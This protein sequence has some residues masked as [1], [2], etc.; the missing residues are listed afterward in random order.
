M[1]QSNNTTGLHGEQNEANAIGASSAS[2]ALNV[3]A[4]FLANMPP[5]V[6]DMIDAAIRLAEAHGPQELGAFLSDEANMVIW[7]PCVLL[8][9]AVLTWRWVLRHI[10]DTIAAVF[11]YKTRPKRESTLVNLFADESSTVQ[12]EGSEVLGVHIADNDAPHYV[13]N[14]HNFL[15]LRFAYND[16]LGG[17]VLWIQTHKI[18]MDDETV[19]AGLKAIRDILVECAEKDV[20]FCSFYDLRTYQLPGVSGGYARANQLIAWC[21]TLATPQKNLINDHIHSVA[22]IL[23]SGFAARILKKIVDFFLWATKPPMDPKIFMDDADAGRLFL[24][25]R[26]KLYKEGKL[27]PVEKGKGP[28]TPVV[29]GANFGNR[30]GSAGGGADGGEDSSGAENPGLP[31]PGRIERSRTWAASS[32]SPMS[33][34]SSRRA[35]SAKSPPSTIKRRMSM[36]DRLRGRRRKP[37]AEE[38][39][40]RDLGREFDRAS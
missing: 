9:V 22:I 7:V 32:S 23:P 21:Q 10:V 36:A 39:P 37:I 2:L 34:P 6:R 33:I 27:R 12:R 29:E 19:T 31:S 8:V 28:L 25:E 13:C 1:E 20:H 14:D 11:L 35:S 17:D 4:I 5:A 40:T 3:A 18:A 26:M 16:E 30:S 24:M 15:H 38:T